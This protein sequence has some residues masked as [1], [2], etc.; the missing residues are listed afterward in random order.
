MELELKK[1]VLVRVNSQHLCYIISKD[2]IEIDMIF[3][4]GLKV[5]EK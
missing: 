3:K 5:H 1:E 2:H 4:Q